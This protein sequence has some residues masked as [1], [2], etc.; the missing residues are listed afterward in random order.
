MPHRFGGVSTRRKRAGVCQRR[1][2]RR[3]A[4]RSA[5]SLATYVHTSTFMM[6]PWPV[7]ETS[8]ATF[9]V[10]CHRGGDLP[11][12]IQRVSSFPAHGPPPLRLPEDGEP[13]HLQSGGSGCRQ[14]FL[15]RF[16]SCHREE[17]LLQVHPSHSS[18]P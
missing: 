9:V 11:M 7:W 5:K 4:V 14:L 3:F 13:V 2:G 1:P 8:F 12:D 16:K 10:S 15:L 17:R 6:S 18:A